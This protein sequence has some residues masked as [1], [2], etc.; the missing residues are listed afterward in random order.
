MNTSESSST[1]SVNIQEFHSIGCTQSHQT[2]I[3]SDNDLLTKADSELI[4]RVAEGVSKPIYDLLVEFLQVFIGI[5]GP[6]CNTMPQAMATMFEKWCETCQEDQTVPSSFICIG[7]S[8]SSP[9]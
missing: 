5:P 2:W 3:P 1:P 7:C 8:C 6:F 9:Y 4:L